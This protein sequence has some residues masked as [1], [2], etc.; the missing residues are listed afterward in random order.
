MKANRIESI[1][2]LRG[3]VMVIMALDHVRD[4]FNYGSFFLDP[5]DIQTTTPIL[6]FT[7]FITHYCA[8]VFVFLAGTSA[9]LYGSN[10]SK[11]DLFKFLMTRGLWIVFLE[12]TLNNLIWTFD[13]GKS[14][15][16]FQVLWAIGF[17][18]VC[19]AF[20]IYLPKKWILALGVLIIFGH[21][22]LDGI[23]AEG[24]NIQSIIWYA[25]HQEQI[26]VLDSGVS[27]VFKY[28]VLPWVGLMALGYVFGVIYQKNYAPQRRKKWLLSLGLGALMLF[29]VLRGFNIYGDPSPWQVQD[30]FSKSVFSFFRLTKYPPSLL[31]LLITMGPGLLFLWAIESIKNR[32]TDFF[33][34]FGRVP[35]F[36]YLLHVFV[37]HILAMLLLMA[38]GGNPKDL[39]LTAEV[40]A[41]AKL[42]NYGYSLTIV[43]VVWVAVVLMLY[44][45]S[46]RYMQYK[47][48]HRDQWW[49][50]Y[51]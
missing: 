12:L 8:P 29:F 38:L 51:L 25:L 33:L 40:F 22:L 30:S 18:M 19:L 42:I 6:F 39:I 23:H 31:Y 28:P 20:I 44:P 16:I 13:L 32:L 11:F 50:S 41:Q 21:N 4:Y 46:K 24:Q 10:K 48:A 14:M 34:V 36:Y 45:L 47:A 43:Y 35:M 17:S 49:L 1:D 3:V 15:H 26:L 2:I 37:I 9:F 7:R 27:V 5:T